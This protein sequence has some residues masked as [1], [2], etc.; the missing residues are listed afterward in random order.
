[1][2]KRRGGRGFFK[3]QGAPP[4]WIGALDI[5]GP[6]IFTISK[7]YPTNFVA[8]VLTMWAYDKTPRGPPSKW[9]AQTRRPGA[10]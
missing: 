4:W 10:A 2:I 3:F 9:A 1:M 5:C 8:F 7:K 6:Y